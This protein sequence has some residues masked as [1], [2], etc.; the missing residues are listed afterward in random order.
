MLAFC[1]EKGIG[2]SV[3]LRPMDEVNACLPPTTSCVWRSLPLREARR[4]LS[5]SVLDLVSAHSGVCVVLRTKTHLPLSKAHI[6]APAQLAGGRTFNVNK[7]LLAPPRRAAFQ[8]N[9]EMATCS[10]A[11][12]ISPPVVCLETR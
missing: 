11:E 1:A 12:W 8:S 4:P 6:N 7:T 2:A 9:C 10:I 3:V 5:P